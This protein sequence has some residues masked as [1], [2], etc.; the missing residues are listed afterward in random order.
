MRSRRTAGFTLIE[1]LVT[2]LISGL[3]LGIAVTQFTGTKKQ[4][5]SADGRGLI[6]SAYES[7][8]DYYEGEQNSNGSG[9]YL[10]LNATVMDRLQPD[11]DWLDDATTSGTPSTSA[12]PRQI[13]IMAVSDTN[14]QL[15]NLTALYAYCV[16]EVG[17]V[18]QYGASRNTVAEALTRATGAANPT[19]QESSRKAE[20]FAERGSC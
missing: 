8:Q 13:K 7:I 4:A 18:A 6:T 3:A 9:T 11:I 2:V 10:G 12:N 19:C 17:G 14:V 1:L 5:A 15:C 16:T 20:S